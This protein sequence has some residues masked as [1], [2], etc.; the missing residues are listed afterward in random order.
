M[1]EEIKNMDMRIFIEFQRM[2]HEPETLELIKN[3]KICLDDLDIH[4]ILDI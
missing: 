2:I 4:D 1:I 3:S